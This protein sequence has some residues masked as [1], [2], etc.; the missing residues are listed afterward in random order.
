MTSIGFPNKF[1][2]NV[3]YVVATFLTPIPKKFLDWIPLNKVNWPCMSKWVDGSVFEHYPDKVCWQRLLKN[4]D[5]VDFIE[6]NKIG[7]FWNILARNENAI[8]L[9]E[10]HFFDITK[11]S[12]DNSYRKN[13]AYI[14]KLCKNRNA[15][16]LIQNYIDQFWINKGKLNWR[17]LSKNPGAIELL[18]NNLDRVDWYAL[19]SNENI[20]SLLEQLPEK[21]LGHV[22]LH[23]IDWEELLPTTAFFPF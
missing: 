6:Q 2:K 21:E 7:I 9:L 10:K 20:I 23:I 3:S 19:L 8:H 5:A 13:M 11:D 22:M 14:N 17:R 12:I 15:V 18:K 16:H 1:D 4:K